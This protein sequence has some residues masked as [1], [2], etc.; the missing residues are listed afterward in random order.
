[1][2]LSDVLVILEN[3]L[4]HLQENVKLAAAE[5]S[6]EQTVMLNNDIDSTTTTIESIKSILSGS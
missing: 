2:K 5:G 1:M 6:L 3:R 4:I